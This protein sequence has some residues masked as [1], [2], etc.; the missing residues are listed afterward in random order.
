[1]KKTFFIFTL[2][3]LLLS[4]CNSKNIVIKKT[5]I[6][7][8][9]K[10]DYKQIYEQKPIFETD[11]L[12]SYFFSLTDEEIVAQLFLVSM[13]GNSKEQIKNIVTDNKNAP[14]GFLLFAFN[15]P[16]NAEKMIEFMAE[17]ENAYLKNGQIPPF[18]SIDHEGGVVNR[19]RNVCSKLPSQLSVQQ[20]FTAK[21]AYSLYELHGIQLKNLGIHVNLAPVVEVVN[22]ENILFLGDRSY[23][24]IEQVTQYSSAQ[25]SGMKKAGILP[26]LKHF[27]G[28]TNNDPHTGLPILNCDISTL[29]TEFLEPFYRL[30]NDTMIGVLVAHTVIPV[31][32]NKPSCLSADVIKLLYENTSFN[33]LIFSDDLL[34]KALIQN[35]Y[36]VDKSLVEVINSGV[37]I[38]MISTSSYDE[39]AEIVLE[40]YRKN[41]EFK[42]KVDESVKKILEWKIS[43]NLLKRDYTETGFF[44][45]DAEV[46]L[47]CEISASQITSRKEAFDK[48]YA[49]ATDLYNEI[50]WSR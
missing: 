47:P 17:L 20:K 13:E 18:I 22:D 36:P 16:E 50:W 32:D 38:L 24:N 45:Y 15:I 42:K 40:E 14:G 8:I 5:D 43:C 44:E 11:S 2:C 29:K 39:Y 3:I 28:N 46:H 27:P 1:M 25:I 21:E 34:M 48:A 6:Q 23:G 31:I 49:E 26:V 12:N 35:G 37:N 41:D 4:S 10:K 19:L 9:F 7:D 30:L 33:G